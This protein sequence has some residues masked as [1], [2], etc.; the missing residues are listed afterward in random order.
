M[1]GGT[2]FMGTECRIVCIIGS[3][4]EL[5]CVGLRGS[6]FPPSV[7]AI[8]D[9][10]LRAYDQV[11]RF[12][13]QTAL[14]LGQR[15]ILRNKYVLSNGNPSAG[16]LCLLDWKRNARVR[17]RKRV[18]RT[19]ATEKSGPKVFQPFGLRMNE[20]SI[21]SAQ[22]V[23]LLRHGAQDVFGRLIPVSPGS[24]AMQGITLADID[25]WS[26]GVF[27]RPVFNLAIPYGIY[28]SSNAGTFRGKKSI[29]GRLPARRGYLLRFATA[30]R[31]GVKSSTGARDILFNKLRWT[32]L[33]AGNG[34]HKRE[35][36]L[37][38][39]ARLT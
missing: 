4:N 8:P 16:V 1:E 9:V 2:Y 38:Y 30:G 13:E 27:L 37:I 3:G 24:R 15:A 28:Y 26:A 11:Y 39:S 17:W 21:V 36:C 25:T 19:T 35:L 5:G 29:H 31:V 7:R 20:E 6:P 33:L 23:L 14:P 10:L 34:F 12:D 32:M 18:I 22:N